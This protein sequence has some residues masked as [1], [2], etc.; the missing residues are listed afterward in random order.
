MSPIRPVKA[1]GM[2]AGSRCGAER[3]ENFLARVGGVADLRKC[4]CVTRPASRPRRVL[5]VMG[6]DPVVVAERV[7]ARE[8]RVPRP[9]LRPVGELM[10][11]DPAPA[12]RLHPGGPRQPV[13]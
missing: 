9:L 11:R 7:L 2:E 13:A 3:M 6:V 10:M 5:G 4:R 8:R 1:A 12:G